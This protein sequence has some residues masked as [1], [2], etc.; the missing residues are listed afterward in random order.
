MTPNRKAHWEGVYGRK[1]AE[2]TSWYQAVPSVS[3]ELIDHCGLEGSEPLIDIGGGASRLVDHLL[4]R[5]FE[6]ISVLDLSARALDQAKMRLGRDAARVHWI[7]ADVTLFRPHR[8]YRLWHDRA[9]FHFLT[10][11]ADRQRYL[12]VLGEALTPGGHLVLAA[13][14]LDGPSRCSGLDVVRYDAAGLAAELGPGFS[15]LEER[16][17]RH[18]TPQGREQQFGY[19]RFRRE[20]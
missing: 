10:G 19:Y 12:E 14:A 20:T 1:Q 9:A 3:L 2:E 16:R 7:E 4:A 18:T 13:F 5:G 11:T 15:L 6:D 8:T 17:E